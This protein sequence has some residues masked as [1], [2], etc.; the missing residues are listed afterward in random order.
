MEHL[1]LQLYTKEIREHAVQLILKQLHRV[2]RE[3]VI[4]VIETP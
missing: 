3:D 2:L 4:Q 1:P